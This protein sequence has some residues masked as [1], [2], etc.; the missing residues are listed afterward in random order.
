MTPEEELYQALIEYDALMIRINRILDRPH[1]MN[2]IRF[3]TK[4]FCEMANRL[5]MGMHDA[6]AIYLTSRLDEKRDQ[7]KFRG[8][9]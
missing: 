1:A 4:R 9:D 5:P 3:A 6:L 2:A 8:G 7:Q